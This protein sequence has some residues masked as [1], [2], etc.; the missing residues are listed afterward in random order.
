[1]DIGNRLELFVD[2]YL[3][4]KLDG[5]T[6]KLHHPKP[7]GVA[8]KLDK[9]WEG[10]DSGY[11]TVLKDREVY[12]M[13]YRGKPGRDSSYENSTACCA[14]SSDGRPTPWTPS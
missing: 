7:A 1:M 3:I 8:A 13:Y 2:R 10:R 5:T 12:R 6:L 4:E 9:P 14:E 11:I